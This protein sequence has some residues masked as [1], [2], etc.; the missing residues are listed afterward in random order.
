VPA[1][2]PE[3]ADERRTSPIELL[4]DLVFVFAVTQVTTLFSRETTWAGFGRSMLILALVWWAW[5]AFVWV[6]NVQDTSSRTLRSALLLATLCI[7]ITGLA[8]PH[9]FG[10]DAGLF[11]CTFAERFGLFVIICLGESIVTIGAGAT[12]RALSPTLVVAVSLGLLIAIGMWWTYFDRVASAAEERLGKQEDAVLAAADAYSYLHLVIVAGIIIFAVGV[13]SLVQGTVSAPLSDAA[14]L[15]L[16]GGVAVYLIGN[17]GFRLRMLGEVGYAQAATAIV[18]MGLYAL[19]SGLAGW[20]LAG[21]V[22]V[23]LAVL[24]AVES[25]ARGT[26]ESA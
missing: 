3:L 11:V 1:E 23:L 19:G 9:A 26:L 25:R 4:W 22:A 2:P 17:V 21:T 6:V 12:H 13:K 15:A 16:C 20:T 5:S 24:C 18:L 7:F 8:V 14:R 10:S